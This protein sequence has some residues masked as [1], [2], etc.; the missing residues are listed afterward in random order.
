LQPHPVS[1]NQP[2]APQPQSTIPKDRLNE[3]WWARKHAAVLASIQANPEPELILVGDSI[4]QNYEKSNPPDENFQPTWQ[5]FYAPRHALNLGY[6]GDATQNVLWRLDN[7]EIDGIDPAAA[8]VLIGTNNT[9]HLAESASETEQGIDAVVQKLETR[10]PHTHILL[11]GILPSNLAPTVVAAD[12]EINQYLAAKY[13]PATGLPDARVT[14][15]D[16]GSIFLPDGK[17]DDSLFYDPRLPQPGRA[18]HPDTMGQ[19]RMAEAIEPVLSHII[20][21]S[22][23]Q[24]LST[25]HQVNTAL[26][27]APR[28]E[29]D[30]YDW[31]K[32]HQQILEI[33]N[34]IDPQ[35]VLIGDSITH[36]WSGE[37][38]AE[39]VNG[40]SA[41]Q[42]AFHDLRVL[43]MG[44]GWDRTQNVLWRLQHG[45]FNG[46]HPKTVVLNIGTNN[47]TGTANARSNT[48]EEITQA[49]LELHRQVRLKSPQS[50]I[51]VMAIF[52][53]MFSPQSDLRH[54]ISRL[55]ELLAKALDG[56]PNTTFLDIG[57]QFLAPDGTLPTT[58][59]EDGTHPTDAG[60]AIWANALIQAGI[61]K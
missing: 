17:L 21:D 46:M 31:Y 53:R 12:R 24:Y 51:I 54:S 49:I 36:F 27:P 25:L 3:S 59:M 43:N 7:G 13:G 9:A 42:Q 55:N 41:W 50:Q 35:I 29:M 44:F 58:M 48:P 39:T 56:Q 52:P 8:L 15:L 14:Y 38:K 33:Q 34:K 26:I 57:Q 5:Q 4:T 37:P 16:I 40:P 2:A 28:L 61:R 30:S 22:A 19:H 18:L 47:L 20:G 32:R 45:E 23:R 1:S 10:L 11:L 6:S 60:Y